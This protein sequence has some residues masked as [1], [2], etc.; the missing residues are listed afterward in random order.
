MLVLIISK[1]SSIAVKTPPSMS[2]SDSF[3]RQSNK[4]SSF[5]SYTTVNDNQ[6]FTCNDNIDRIVL[7]LTFYF[8]GNRYILKM[9]VIDHIYDEFVVDDLAM[10]IILPE[11][12]T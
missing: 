4:C 5:L 7:F 3:V 11:G 9:R 1:T 8:L 2:Q 10:R 6:I 12:C